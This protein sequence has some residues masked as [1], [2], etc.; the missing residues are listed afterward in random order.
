MDEEKKT[1]EGEG[2]TTIEF[3]RETTMTI[4]GIQYVVTSHFDDS[5]EDLKTKVAR[6]LKNDVRE[7]IRPT[8]PPDEAV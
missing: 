7:M 2:V 6:L 5:Q 1:A 4:R 8:I 3:E